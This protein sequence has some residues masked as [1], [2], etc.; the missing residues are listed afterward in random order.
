MPTVPITANTLGQM[1]IDIANE[2][3]RPDLTGP[4]A[5]KIAEAIDFYQPERFKFS[6]SRDITFS[7]VA[8]QEFYGTA[9]NAAIPTLEAFDYVILYIGSIPWPIARRTDVEIEVLNQNGLM[10]GQPWNWSYY[11]KQLRLG[12]VPD[13]VYSMRI[14][15]H[16]N[17]PPPASDAETGNVWMIDAERLI[18]SR[19]KYELFVHNIRNLEQAQV[20]GAAVSEAFDRLKGEANRL[21]GRAVTAPMEF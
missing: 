18:R 14:A 6:E 19:A 12:P 20:M 9:D 17:V 7:T 2:I 10:K 13:T 1:K 16:R 8:G 15:C 11:N 3:A 4:I 5:M 21:V